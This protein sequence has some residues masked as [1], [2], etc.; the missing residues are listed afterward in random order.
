MNGG[1][2]TVLG[3]LLLAVPAARA[4][5]TYTTNSD[6]ISIT[7]TGYTNYSPIV[8]IPT[9]INGLDVTS[10]GT[11]AFYYSGVTSIT[12]PDTVT[13]IGSNAFFFSGLAS[14]TIPANVTSI[15][16]GA[17]AL[18]YQLTAFTVDTNN[19]NF[20]SVNGVLFDKS[21][22]TLIQF[23]ITEGGSYAI[24][25]TVTSI[26]D[27]AL[28]YCQ[29][30]TNVTI[31]D[32]V[33]TIGA[34]AFEQCIGL[35]SV[36]IP[37]SVTSIGPEA[38]DDCNAVTNVSLGR[39]VKDIGSSAFSDCWHLTGIMIPASVTNI[40]S[41]AFLENSRM[42]AITVNPNNSNYCSVDGVLFDKNQTTLIE[43]P[44]HLN[45]GN[46]TV[47]G[48]VTT[49]ESYAFYECEH[50]TNIAIPNSVTSIG[51]N[52]FTFCGNL[53]SVTIP[54]NVGKIGYGTFDYC[55][56][57]TNVTI[58]G[59]ATNIGA[60]A[61]ADESSLAGVFF[62]GNAPTVNP[63]AFLPNAAV[64]LVYA[65]IYYLPGT[66]GWSSPIAGCQVVLWNPLIQ[67]SGASFGV[68]SNQFGFN[69]TGTTNIPVVVEACTNLASPVWTPLQALAVTNGLAYFTDPQ[70]TNYPDRYYHIAAP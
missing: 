36:T 11:N 15:G 65:T 5:F 59:S 41:N 35:T 23:P 4:Q 55:E 20:S 2:R 51:A 10:I 7:I 42:T 47:P 44:T 37:D 52:A 69:I 6:G 66:T 1:L 57:F 67:A 61:F 49:I 32:G 19:P 30:L 22:S 25:G 53:R 60:Y 3:L 13:N 56:S 54:S 26:G 33:T 9:N 16:D 45:I 18:C 17:F 31:P 50:L 8:V 62:A 14:V 24:P 28:T 40:G 64:Q 27:Y 46:F 21:Q 38:F 12:I 34:M 63:N 70:W 68:Q 39:A 58:P 29:N 48:T 43:S